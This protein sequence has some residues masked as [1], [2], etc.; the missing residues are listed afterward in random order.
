MKL[1][2]SPGMKKQDRENS[3]TLK[4]FMMSQDEYLRLVNK[5]TEDIQCKFHCKKTVFNFLN[6]ALDRQISEIEEKINAQHRQMGGVHNSHQRHVTT[7]VS[8]YPKKH[9]EDDFVM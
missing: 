1:A 4:N 8:L 6:S 2:N 7:Q 9:V 3:K 5:E